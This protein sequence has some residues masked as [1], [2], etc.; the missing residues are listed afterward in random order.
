MAQNE[1]S[2]KEIHARLS[3]KILEALNLALEQEDVQVSEQL[4]NALELAMTRSTGGKE[5]VERREYPED[6]DAALKK[7]T[8]I[9][10]KKGLQ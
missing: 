9:R 4:I 5:Y 6:V 7:Y 3:D 10:R 8:E 2:Q 1:L